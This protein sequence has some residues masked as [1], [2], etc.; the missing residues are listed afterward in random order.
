MNFSDIDVFGDFGRALKEAKKEAKEQEKFL[1]TLNCANGKRNFELISP[2]LKKLNESACLQWSESPIMKKIYIE[3]DK[4]GFGMMDNYFSI[5]FVRSDGSKSPWIRFIV[6]LDRQMLIPTY[7]QNDDFGFYCHTVP[8]K[9]KC[10]LVGLRMADNSL[11][12]CL[13]FIAEY[14]ITPDDFSVC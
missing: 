9:N 5:S 11:H 6:D 14:G 1:K 2:F 13:Q 3:T 7:Y 10:D 12:Q 4:I 8:E